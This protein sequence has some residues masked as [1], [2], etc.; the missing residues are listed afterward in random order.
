[1]QLASLAECGRPCLGVALVDGRARVLSVSQTVSV[2]SVDKTVYNRMQRAELAMLTSPTF[3]VSLQKVLT[4]SR[5]FVP[6]TREWHTGI[7][8][9]PYLV[10]NKNSMLDKFDN[11]RCE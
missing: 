6:S 3:L 11:L 5:F 9:L 10:L 1:M 8:P 2:V 7:Q 4:G